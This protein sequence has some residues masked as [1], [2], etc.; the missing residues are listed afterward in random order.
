MRQVTRC[1]CDPDMPDEE[2][3]FPRG[4]R[5][6]F[7]ADC[8][9]CHGNYTILRIDTMIA[10]PTCKGKGASL[11]IPD[12]AKSLPT[13]GVILS[14]GPD[15]TRGG[16]ELNKRVICTPHSGVFLPMKGNIPIKVFRQHEPLCIMYN[17]KRDG[18]ADKKDPGEL[19]T[20]K[21]V[22]ID[23]PLGEQFNA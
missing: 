15:V 13:T 18:T 21:F 3:P 2:L 8:E 20:S 6:R 22:E 16:I 23:T 10:C 14:V 17:I 4:A 5:N 1:I 7:G 9:K 19:A 12:T 11:F